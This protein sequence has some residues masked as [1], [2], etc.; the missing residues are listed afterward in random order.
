MLFVCLYSLCMCFLF[1][2]IPCACV[3]FP[4]VLLSRIHLNL[5]CLFCFLFCFTFH[6]VVLLFFLPFHMASMP[7]LIQL[8]FICCCF[9]P[10]SPGL[11]FSVTATLFPPFCLIRT[12]QFFVVVAVASLLFNSCLVVLLFCLVLTDFYSSP[13]TTALTKG[14]IFHCSQSYLFTSSPSIPSI[15][16]FF[17]SFSLLTYQAQ[18]GQGL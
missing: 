9:P 16:F 15:P 7:S 4:P 2:C 12:T 6:S 8:V 13:K 11:Y 10:L 5:L 1:V 17:I 14:T 18:L 3:Y